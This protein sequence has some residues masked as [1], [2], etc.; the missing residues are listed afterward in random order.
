MKLNWDQQ[1]PVDGHDLDYGATPVYVNGMVVDGAKDGIVRAYM[2]STGTQA[3]TT[4]AGI[5][6]GSIIGSPATDGSHI[7]VPYVQAPGGGA[8]VALNLNGSVAWTLPTGMDQYGF[9]VLSAPAVSQSMVFVAYTDVNCTIAP[10]NGISAL[11]A[12]TGQVLW[13]YKTKHSIYAGPAIVDGG[14]FVG[15]FDG[16]S[17]YCFTPGGV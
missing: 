17:L 12:N 14:L 1:G 5:V 13:R 4:N 2:T 9:G 6:G 8:I 7:F 3:W 16:T 11:D 10:C 15:E